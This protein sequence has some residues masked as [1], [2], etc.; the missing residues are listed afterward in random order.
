MDINL[1]E[2]LIESDIT[3]IV[4]H[5]YI[6]SASFSISDIEKYKINKVVQCIPEATWFL[7][8]I[9]DKEIKNLKKARVF[10]NKLRENFGFEVL[11]D[12]L[13]LPLNDKEEKKEVLKELLN[14]SYD[15]ID[16]AV[17]KNKNVLIYCKLGI[18]RSPFVCINYLMKKNNIDYEKAYK[19]VEEKR[20]V[21]NPNK[22][23]VDFLK[24]K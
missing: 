10:Q 1:F 8:M 11:E 5:I 14:I 9:A 16:D 3:G 18:S 7:S 19:M 22:I 15:Y 12:V 6:G 21:I 20:N 4:P 2:S 13:F 24:K 23:F 17:N